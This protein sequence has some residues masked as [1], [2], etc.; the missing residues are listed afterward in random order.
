MSELFLDASFAIALSASSD[1]HHKRALELAG[2]IEAQKDRLVTTHG[3]LL[4]IGDAL[5]R[6]RHRRAAIELLD[7]IHVDPTI[8]VVP[9]I[10]A[11]YDRAFALYR[12]REDKE[13]GMTDCVS[14]VVMEERGIREALTA[15]E[16]FRQAGFEALLLG[17]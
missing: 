2:L 10:Q 14:F 17:G 5:S 7:A 6:Q 16:H 13:W 3:V 15:D 11:L 8:E 4:E 12:G 1:Q 9:L